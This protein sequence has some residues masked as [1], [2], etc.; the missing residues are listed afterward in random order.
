MACKYVWSGWQNAG[1]RPFASVYVVGTE[2]L[3]DKYLGI[4]VKQHMMRGMGASEINA[5]EVI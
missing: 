1:F 3:F 2:R 4:I 5:S